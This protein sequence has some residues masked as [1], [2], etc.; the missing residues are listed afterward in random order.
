MGKI[1]MDYGPYNLWNDD[2][3]VESL[4]LTTNESFNWGIRGNDD[5]CGVTVSKELIDTITKE[6]T[7]HMWNEHDEIKTIEG[8]YHLKHR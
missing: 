1:N 3:P 5:I 7:G 6:V 4:P 8:K 2:L